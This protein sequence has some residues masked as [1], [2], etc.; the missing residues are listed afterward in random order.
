MFSKYIS[1]REA[2][3]KGPDTETYLRY[4]EEANVLGNKWDVIRGSDIRE[5][6]GNWVLWDL[7]GN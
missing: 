4:S 2:N 6:S 3:A 7:V 1:R 5:I